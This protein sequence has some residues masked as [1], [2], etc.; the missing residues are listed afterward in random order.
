MI[1]P[2]QSLDDA[3]FQTL[4]FFRRQIA[5]RQILRQLFATEQNELRFE[6]RHESLRRRFRFERIRHEKLQSK[7][8]VQHVPR[9]RYLRPQVRRLRR[10]FG[11]LRIQFRQLRRDEFVVLRR[12]SLIVLRLDDAVN[13]VQNLIPFLLRQSFECAC[14]QTIRFVDGGIHHR[15]IRRHPR[16]TA[17]W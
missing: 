3:Q 17:Y 11:Y 6:P 4:N 13:V 7:G 2:R 5:Q 1:R 9:I 12:L 16:R 10:Y 14:T 8:T 15:R